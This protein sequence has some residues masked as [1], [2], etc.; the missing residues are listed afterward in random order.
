MLGTNCTGIPNPGTT[1]GDSSTCDNFTVTN[2]GATSLSGIVYQWQS[3]T[4]Q[5]TWADISGA[6]N[7]SYSSTQ[8]ASTY[9]RLMTICT[10]G[11]DTVYSND[12]YVV[13]NAATACYCIPNS[14]SGCIYGD[15]I[16]R[17]ILN[18]LD[19]NSG[20]GCP[21]GTLGYSDYSQDAL[22]TTTLMPSSTY[23]CEVYVGAYAVGIAVWIDYNDDGIFDNATERVGYSNGQVPANTSASF[24]VTL[25]CTPPAGQHRMRVRAMYATNGISVDPCVANSYGET[26]DYTITIAAPPSCPSPGAMYSVA[27]TSSSADLEW[28]LGCSSATAFELEYGPAGFAQGSG[29]TIS[30]VTPSIVN[31]T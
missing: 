16:A 27:V 26:E 29:T 8:T 2:T 19:N 4:D 7:A 17:V 13:Q 25:S 14:S 30:G 5:I 18:S 10:A 12:W 6:N 15:E 28:P 20:T 21:S 23:S 11:N 1:T 31:D 22:L 3:S 9:Y 24:P